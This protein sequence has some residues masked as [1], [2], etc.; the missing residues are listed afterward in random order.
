[1][2]CKSK[3]DLSSGV[4]A[5]REAIDDEVAKKKAEYQDNPEL[6]LISNLCETEKVYRI[7]SCHIYQISYYLLDLVIAKLT[8]L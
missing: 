5:H 1:M 3:A 2:V 8:F 6:V 7:V 4:G